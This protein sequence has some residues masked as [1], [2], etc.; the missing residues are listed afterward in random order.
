MRSNIK[1]NGRK[2]SCILYTAR[3]IILLS[4]AKDRKRIG[5]E[6]GKLRVFKD[7]DCTF[8]VGVKTTTPALKGL[9]TGFVPART[10]L[11]SCV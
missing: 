7:T 10:E 8:G 6:M 2:E 3:R 11:R 5:S 4:S 1:K 9:R